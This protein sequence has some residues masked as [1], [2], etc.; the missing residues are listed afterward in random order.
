[1]VTTT[2]KCVPRPLVSTLDELLTDITRSLLEK[3]RRS[4][5]AR[6]P[7]PSQVRRRRALLLQGHHTRYDPEFFIRK[8]LLPFLEQ[9]L[10]D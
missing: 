3:V 9:R 1:M 8:P 2:L 4:V 5:A 7:W 10:I 6:L